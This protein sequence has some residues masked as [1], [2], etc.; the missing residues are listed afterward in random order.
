MNLTQ[1]QLILP[2]SLLLVFIG[3]GIFGIATRPH[4]GRVEGYDRGV[5]LP[6]PPPPADP[7]APKFP[8]VPTPV[9]TLVESLN[10]TYGQVADAIFW[11]EG[12]AK[13]RF[14]YGVMSYGLTTKKAR[15]L[16]L[17]TVTNSVDR[18]TFADRP[19]PFL[20]FLANRYCPE[21]VDPVGY[22][23]WIVNVR[24]F[25]DHPKAALP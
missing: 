21:S 17:Q 22:A 9:P 19:G 12:G 13:T 18:W 6:L 25:L 2:C 15:T 8:S 24:W 4:G 7:P 10:A 5:E 16:C 3:V 11:T 14:P 1:K 23:N 20:E